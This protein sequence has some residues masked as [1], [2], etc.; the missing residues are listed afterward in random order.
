MKLQSTL[1]NTMFPVDLIDAIAKHSFELAF[2]LKKFQ[3]CK[4]IRRKLS[5]KLRFTYY[6]KYIGY[7][8]VYF[9]DRWIFE[10]G[11][12]KFHFDLDPLK[13]IM[14]T[15]VTH[16]KLSGSV[17]LVIGDKDI[18]T[19]LS[20]SES[21][22]EREIDLV[23]NLYLQLDNGIVLNRYKDLTFFGIIEQ[24]HNVCHA[25]YM[26]NG[27]MR[28][29]F[30][31]GDYIIKSQVDYSHEWIQ[32]IQ[33]KKWEV[34]VDQYKYEVSYALKDVLRYFDQ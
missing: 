17:S 20:L 33:Y 3:I 7:T 10:K 30:K 15:P 8:D 14:S 6:A 12:K 27:I 22:F 1:H 24:F 4:Q 25:I 2:K 28:S 9:K 21:S 18:G 16:T 31:F 26:F 34:D 29:E 11:C 32:D 13:K 5:A 19:L 23:F